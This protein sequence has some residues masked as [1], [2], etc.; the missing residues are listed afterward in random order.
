[1]DDIEGVRR[2]VLLYSQLLDDT[3]YDEWEDLF[4]ADAVLTV[5]GNTYTGRTAIR[6]G[7]EAMTPERPGK[8]VAYATVADFDGDEA[9]AWTD[10]T[11]LADSGAGQWG[12]SYVVAT[13]ARYYDHVVR[14]GGQWMFARRQIRMAGEPLPD[15]ARTSPAR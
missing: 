11:A 7:I 2:L 13:V 15:G 6:E 8:H 5:W 1:M 3:R 9:W 14:R 12:R 4:T 10:F